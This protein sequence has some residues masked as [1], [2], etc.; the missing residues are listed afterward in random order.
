LIFGG[1]GRVELTQRA[2]R[3]ELK[4]E[5]IRRDGRRHVDELEWVVSI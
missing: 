5:Q 2:I 3:V 4:T 1:I